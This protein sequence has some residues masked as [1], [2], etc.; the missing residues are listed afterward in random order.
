[1]LDPALNIWGKPGIGGRSMLD[2]L[3][4]AAE[5]SRYLRVG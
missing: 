5:A 3:W 4:M 1:M 2:W